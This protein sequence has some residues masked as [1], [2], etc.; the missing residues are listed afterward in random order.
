[1]QYLNIGYDESKEKYDEATKM[2]ITN[3]KYD[4][5]KNTMLNYVIEEFI[6]DKSDYVRK[7]QGGVNYYIS[8]INN[9]TKTGNLSYDVNININSIQKFTFKEYNNRLVIDSYLKRD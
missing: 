7:S 2:V 6:K 9:I 1:M 4:D 8:T 5:F 3:V